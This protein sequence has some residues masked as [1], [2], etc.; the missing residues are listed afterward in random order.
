MAEKR[1]VLVPVSLVPR[2]SR[3]E[4]LAETF[5]LERAWRKRFIEI[6]L[7]RFRPSNRS[8]R[9]VFLDLE[10]LS[11]GHRSLSVCFRSTFELGCVTV[12][13]TPRRAAR[14]N[15]E[16]RDLINA[17]RTA[18]TSVAVRD[19]TTERRIT[20]PKASEVQGK[21]DASSEFLSAR[22]SCQR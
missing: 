16:H 10:K 19:N 4:S 8:S 14:T 18:I 1:V 3:P 21:A 7:A 13:Q 20:R 5:I 22:D 2:S 17:K 15:G 12:A 6:P 9:V 11:A